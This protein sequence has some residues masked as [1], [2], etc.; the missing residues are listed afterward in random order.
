MTDAATLGQIKTSM[1]AA[2]PLV[3][4]MKIE[5]LTVTETSA[6][7]RLADQPGLR[8]HVGGL[9]AG[10]MFTLGES[11]SGAVVLGAF[12]DLLERATP[13]AAGA[14]ITYLKLALGD[15][16]AT[17]TLSVDAALVRTE[18]EG[19]GLPKFDVAVELTDAGGTVT[20]AMTVHWAL[21]P[22]KRDE[23]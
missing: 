15:I 2:V 12:A 1:P 5:Y 8:N 7:L 6:H 3:A 21:K 17:A 20:A 18:L 16:D 4:T 22:N 23:G 9:H 10:A 14:E 13:L 19:G 11:A